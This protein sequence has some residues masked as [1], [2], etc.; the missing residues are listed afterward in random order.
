MPSYVP[1]ATKVTIKHTT[2]H[3]VTKDLVFPEQ[4]AYS[5]SVFFLIHFSSQKLCPRAPAL[6][7]LHN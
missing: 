7:V 1:V 2:T 6:F 4:D 3:R 5:V